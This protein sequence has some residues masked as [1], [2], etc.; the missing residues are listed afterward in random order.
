MIMMKAKVML[1]ACLALAVPSF[2][3]AGQYAAD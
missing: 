2:A 1:I 3:V